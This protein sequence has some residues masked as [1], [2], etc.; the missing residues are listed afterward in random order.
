MVA[1]GT[2]NPFPILKSLTKSCAA[3]GICACIYDGFH[4]FGPRMTFQKYFSLLKCQR[5]FLCPAI[6]NQSSVNH[7]VPFPLDFSERT[8][9]MQLL[10]PRVTETKTNTQA[11]SSL[12]KMYPSLIWEESS[13]RHQPVIVVDG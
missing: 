8:V 13:W 6:V 9:Q 1:K 10:H 2:E 3:V 7:T 5:L 11:R 12:P 4:T